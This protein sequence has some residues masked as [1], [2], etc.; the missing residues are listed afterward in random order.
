MGTLLLARETAILAR[1][2][3]LLA[4]QT[5]LLARQTAILARETAILARQTA[6]LARGTA[7]LARGPAFNYITAKKPGKHIHVVCVPGYSSYELG[8][9]LCDFVS[10][11]LP[12][13]SFSTNVIFE[14]GTPVTIKL[15]SLLPS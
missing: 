10:S 12:Y 1:E 4:R 14:P 2:T 3:A 7:L 15:Y 11:T 9:K 6:I 8:S 13:L 5:A